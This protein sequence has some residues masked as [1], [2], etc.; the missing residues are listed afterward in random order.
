MVREDAVDPCDQQSLAD[1]EQGWGFSELL[2]GR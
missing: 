2:N 1:F